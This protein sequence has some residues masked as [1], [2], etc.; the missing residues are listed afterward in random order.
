MVCHFSYDTRAVDNKLKKLI[1]K[2]ERNLVF[3]SMASNFVQLRKS[4][5][6]PQL[7]TVIFLVN[8]KLIVDGV[9]I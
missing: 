3:S 6:D 4:Y 2:I 1:L 8:I 7:R 9:L 5:E